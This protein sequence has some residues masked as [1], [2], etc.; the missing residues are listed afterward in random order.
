MKLKLTRQEFLALYNIM[1]TLNQKYACQDMQDKLFHVIM[2]RIFIKLHKI[3][4]I[5]K[6]E[7]RVKLSEEEAIAFWIIFNDN[8]LDQASFE[9]NLLNTINNHIHQKFAA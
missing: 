5:V 1:Q 9:G 4:V 6:S 8:G 3:S 2:T 7:C